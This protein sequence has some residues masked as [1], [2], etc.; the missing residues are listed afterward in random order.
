MRRAEVRAI[1]GPPG[2][3]RTGPVYEDIRPAL[4]FP[5]G[6]PQC[7]EWFWDFGYGMVR[8]DSSEVVVYTN[9]ISTERINQSS[10][11]NLL[12]RAKRQWRR[13]FPEH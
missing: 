4:P 1:L 12:W 2:D 11:D 7:D 5:S 3:Y 10:L 13:W 8:F 6:L 9:L